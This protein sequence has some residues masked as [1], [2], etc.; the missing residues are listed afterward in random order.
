MKLLAVADGI[1]GKISDTL[2]ANVH[3]YVIREKATAKGGSRGVRVIKVSKIFNKI[4][5][6][7]KGDSDSAMGIN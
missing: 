5:D 3:Y 7:I 4:L 6:A 1:A 2:A